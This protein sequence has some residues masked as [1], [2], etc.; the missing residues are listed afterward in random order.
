MANKFTYKFEIDKNDGN[1]LVEYTP[2]IGF[3]TVEN[4]NEEL[5][6]GYFEFISKEKLPIAVGSYCKITINDNSTE[7]V[8][9]FYI[10]RDVP[11]IIGK[12][13]N[14][15][16]HKVEI[17]ETTKKLE[18]LDVPL[19]TFTVSSDSNIVNY[20]LATAIERVL[21]CC[22]SFYDIQTKD[23]TTFSNKDINNFF[24]DFT[25][26]SS[27]RD[28]LN[29]IECPELV[30]KNRTLREAIDMILESADAICYVKDRYK[31]SCLFYNDLKNKINELK[32][33][34]NDFDVSFE[35]HASEIVS[36][37]ENLID[38]GTTEL[39]NVIYPSK[40]GWAKVKTSED[41]YSMNDSNFGIL[42]E[43]KIYNV[44]EL[45]V[46]VN[47]FHITVG[48][49][50]K[51]ENYSYTSLEIG[52]ANINLDIS[53]R[54]VEE[55]I[56]NNLAS[57]DSINDTQNKF[58]DKY[59]K[60]NTI[61]F[62][63]NT[64][65]INLSNN[66]KGFLLKHHNLVFSILV[67]F[68]NK[69]KNTNY[70]L[71]FLNNKVIKNE[72]YEFFDIETTS[73]ITLISKIFDAE[74]R[75]EISGDFLNNFIDIDFC[76][77]NDTSLNP[78]K[79]N[80]EYRI[81]YQKLYNS[82][83]EISKELIPSTSKL[84]SKIIS[85]QNAEIISLKQI[86]LNLKSNV[87]RTG[88]ITNSFSK[89]HTS[90]SDLYHIGD[91]TED[92]YVL[93][94]AEYI[95]YNNYILGKYN[96]T[97]NY[98]R[99]NEY[100]GINSRIRQY[101]I[102]NNN[103]SYERM[104]SRINYCFINNKYIPQSRTECT[105]IPNEKFYTIFTN[106][107]TNKKGSSI[108]SCVYHDTNVEPEFYQITGEGSKKSLFIE[109]TS[110]GVGNSLIFNFGF[111]NNINAG[112]YIQEADEIDGREIVKKYL[113]N[114]APYTVNGFNYKCDIKLIDGEYNVNNEY[115]PI[116]TYSEE[117]D[118][119]HT[120]I[121]IKNIYT[122]K[123]PKEILKFTYQLNF[124]N[125][126][127]KIILGNGFSRLNG[128][129][130]DKKDYGEELYWYGLYGGE[131]S[132]NDIYKPLGNRLKKINDDDLVF[133]NLGNGV[134]KLEL[135]FDSDGNSLLHSLGGFNWLA[136]G[137]EKTLIMAIR[138]DFGGEKS[139]Q[140]PIYFNFRDIRNDIIQRY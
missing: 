46:P 21:R 68:V 116:I 75:I 63:R 135:G 80:I 122:E 34:S 5:D 126:S 99:L 16:L 76:S 70:L 91:Y 119:Q 123:D 110:S 103:S 105:F 73:K 72:Q 84:E 78:T 57:D 82:K 36:Y 42:L 114:K 8:I 9:D 128:L 31:I 56:Y 124:I 1:G 132:K 58:S 10:L 4:I 52:Q 118:S 6:S 77:I 69:L 117:N 15:Y 111:N 89:R 101:E 131:Y 71:D 50:Y 27:V 97:N 93:T 32:K 14:T 37:S 90:L 30:I 19:L 112:Y 86:G 2:F 133:T 102:P 12:R 98:S 94:N 139:T 40:T 53:D 22:K 49:T 120:L 28:K 54:L 64:N 108:N 127:D 113:M 129:V 39:V 62:K 83:I 55:E 140:F 59:L 92:G 109:T 47:V 61:Y 24:L 96:F 18:K 121:D 29:S 7:Q 65:F 60:Q 45:F 130:Y 44:F 41:N 87:D 136:I 138:T 38:E 79:N 48:G 26:D 11:S 88:N 66:F 107:F 3:S 35:D 51:G 106:T 125:K 137:N 100:I 23:D 104:I 33:E 85:N 74:Y 95:Y 25:I 43:D 134:M 17:I 115:L 13:E 20:T 67:S 81:S